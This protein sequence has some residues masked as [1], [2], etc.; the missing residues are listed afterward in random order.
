MLLV[1]SIVAIFFPA[2]CLGQNRPIYLRGLDNA[3][4]K[5][6]VLLYCAPPR[7]ETNYYLLQLAAP[8]DADTLPALQAADI[9]V[10][11]YVPEWTYIVRMSPAAAERATTLPSVSWTGLYQ[12]LYK[13][14][15]NVRRLSAGQVI[16]LNVQLFP[17][18]PFAGPAEAARHAGGL[19]VTA[20]E[21][22][23]PKLRIQAPAVA[24]N[25][26][27]DSLSREPGVAWIEHYPRYTMCNDDTIWVCQS[28]L[29][30]GEITPVW[31]RGIHGQGEYVAVLDTGCDADMCYFY[32][33]TYGLPGPP[34]P[35]QRKIYSYQDIYGSN[36]W[37]QVGHGTHTAG[38]VAGDNF[39]NPLAHDVG[40][41]IAPGAKLVIQDAGVP[42]DLQPPD[43]LYGCLGD[44]FDDLARIHSN[45]WGWPSSGAGYHIDSQEVDAFTWDHPTFLSVYA[46]G[47][48]GPSSGTMRA[49]GTA[50][51]VVSVGATLHGASAESNADF[52]SHGPTSDG[53]IKPDVTMPGSGINSAANDY[54]GSSFNCGATTMSGT[55]MATPGV[56]GA[57]ALIR[58]YYADGFYP[59]GAADSGSEF[60]PSAALV[61]ATLINCA[62]NMTGSYTADSGSGHADAPSMGQGWGR[63]N[64]SNTLFFA[65]NARDLFLDDAAPGLTTGGV[66]EYPLAVI[67]AGEP[68]E[69]TLVWSDY[70][71]TPQASVN[72]VND[73]DL[74]L[75]HGTTIYRGNNYS[76]GASVPGGTVDR[77][78]NTECV[79]IAAPEPGLWTVVVRGFL[80]PQGPQPYAMVASG[81]FA[82]SDGIV[83]LDRQRYGCEDQ[84]TVRVSDYDLRGLGTHDVWLGSSS[85][86]EGE[87]LRL[88]ETGVESGVFA[89]ALPTTSAS[90]H[91]GQLLVS[92]GDAVE[93]IYIDE[94][95][96]HGGVNIEKTDSAVIDCTS[97]SIGMVTARD[98]LGDSATI[99]WITNEASDS[100][101]YFDLTIPPTQMMTVAEHVTGHE[102]R[103]TGLS[104]ASQYY[105]Y[106]T[107]RDEAGNVAMDDHQGA[108][109]Q[110]ETLRLAIAFQDDLEFPRGWVEGGDGQWEW[111]RPAGLGGG[112]GILPDPN[113]DH[114]TGNGRAWG[115][116]LT[117]DGRYAPNSAATL[118]SPPIF[119]RNIV[120]TR[121]EF[122]QWLNLS[123]LD[124]LFMDEAILD[125]SNNGGVTW[126]EVWMDDSGAQAEEWTL[127]SHDISE[128]ADG[129]ADVRLRF[130]LTSGFMFESTGWNIDDVNVWGF[131]NGSGFP[132]PTSTWS[133]QPTWTPTPPPWTATPT[134]TATPT[135]PPS[136]PSAT[137]TATTGPGT[138][139]NTPF[140]TTTPTPTTAPSGTPVE[141]T[142]TPAETATPIPPTPTELPAGLTVTLDLNAELFHERDLFLLALHTANDGPAQL[143]DLYL[144]L[145]VTGMY[146]FWPDWTQ[147]IDFDRR[148]F[149]ADAV[150]S[151]TVLEFIW[152]A[153][154]G[155]LSGVVFWSAATGAGNYDLVSNVSRVEFGFE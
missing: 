114:S 87:T 139:T 47:N 69:V 45:S 79:R 113:G 131:D 149:E 72:L 12:P 4:E 83:Q 19:A 1:C 94:D 62:E 43:D 29:Y 106:V 22:Y 5:G 6:P 77:R 121:I 107:S 63:V 73:L 128:W 85:E 152:P 59:T 129:Q 66:V 146:W 27:L 18:E 41:G 58:Q 16:D 23:R 120:G 143:G 135:R 155:A 38:T 125:V 50:K 13:T 82:F 51:N 97:P 144:I 142:A 14:D 101:V 8:P 2:D 20:T 34:N 80:V 110:F 32:D 28:G 103:L 140:P 150:H 104:Q 124:L 95:D 52:S 134:P 37:D 17:G 44:A 26:L 39:A 36:N 9:D 84:I 127:M 74:E 15:P 48:E 76:G 138:P 137:P 35:L 151:D 141:P 91:T 111:A 3:P 136:T 86:P 75:V 93:V 68:L 53:R 145:E 33:S 89:G 108:Y 70:P 81:D 78:N 130:T 67:S 60:D 115:V 154:A 147:E 133:P 98:I 10:I 122:Y 132:T 54:S 119:C 148:Y 55:S 42:G 105:F 123:S 25:T 40:D 71:S 65:G 90:P 31:D 11:D 153:G 109:Y 117:V 7:S 24:L 88:T 112:F 96:G 57:C 100:T 118:I 56:A 30:A 46:M 99:T 21:G 126:H 64:L 61:K 92:E 116:D 49:P 102:V